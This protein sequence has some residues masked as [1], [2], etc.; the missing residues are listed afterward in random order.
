MFG[1]R[2][3]GGLWDVLELSEVLMKFMFDCRMDSDALFY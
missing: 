2:N 3:V 1:D